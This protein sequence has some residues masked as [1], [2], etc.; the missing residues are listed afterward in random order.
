MEKMEE[1]LRILERQSHARPHGGH[2]GDAG[3]TPLDR[4]GRLAGRGSRKGAM[5]AGMRRWW[6][7]NRPVSNLVEAVIE[8]RVDAPEAPFSRWLRWT[9]GA[10]IAGVEE[11]DGVLRDE[12]QL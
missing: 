8:L 12:R 4:G 7:G 2:R 9:F 5:S 1:L 6:T 10:T 3:R 11:V